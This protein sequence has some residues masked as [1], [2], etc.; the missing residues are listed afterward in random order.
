MKYEL[1]V[2]SE[3]ENKALADRACTAQNTLKGTIS[4]SILMRV[5]VYRPTFL[6]GKEVAII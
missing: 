2:S 1:W 6:G 5:W 4:R 3:Q